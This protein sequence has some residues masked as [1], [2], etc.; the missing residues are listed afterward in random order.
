MSELS[1][2][3]VLRNHKPAGSEEGRRAEGERGRERAGVFKGPARRLQK[4]R[5]AS[6]DT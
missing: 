6:S 3:A 5:E 4:A 1:E 2:V